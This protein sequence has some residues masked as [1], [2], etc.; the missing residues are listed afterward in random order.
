[1][2]KTLF[3]HFLQDR[4]RTI[5]Y[6]TMT[7]AQ[8]AENLE[9]ILLAPPVTDAEREARKPDISRLPNAVGPDGV[10]LFRTG[11]KIIIERRSTVLAGNPYLDTRTYTVVGINWDNGNLDLFD[12]SLAQSALSN[13]KTGLQ[14]GYVFKLAR[15]NEVATKKKRGRPRKNPIVDKT[16]AK[17]VP[18]DEEGRPIKKKRGRPPGSKNRDRDTIRIEKKTKMAQ[19]EEKKAKRKSRAGKGKR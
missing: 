16:E 7:E 2:F 12:D 17:A 13:Y 10:P 15:G 4:A 5:Y 8:T 6:E 19:R 18:L 3:A 1:L 11:E 9:D 14:R